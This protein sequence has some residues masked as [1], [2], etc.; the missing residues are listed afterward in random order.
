MKKIN[1]SLKRFDI[2]KDN[3]TPYFRRSICFSTGIFF[4]KDETKI[5]NILKNKGI[6]YIR[7]DEIKMEL[8]KKKRQKLL[9]NKS[10]KKRSTLLLDLKKNPM[11]KKRSLLLAQKG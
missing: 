9:I 1:H 3:N 8:N 10:L 6:N 2:S 11:Y 5:D 7:K 4:T